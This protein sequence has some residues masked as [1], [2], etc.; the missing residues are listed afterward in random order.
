VDRLERQRSPWASSIRWASRITAAMSSSGRRSST[1][2]D[3]NRSH[4]LSGSAVG[5]EP[6]VSTTSARE[7]KGARRLWVS[8]TIVGLISTPR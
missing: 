3:T 7:P 4:E 8:A 5:G 2:L 6:S 1:K